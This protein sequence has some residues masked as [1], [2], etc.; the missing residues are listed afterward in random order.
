[1]PFQQSLEKRELINKEVKE[2]LELGINRPSNS[3][4]AAN[5]HLVDKKDTIAKRMVI[6]FRPLNAV[7]MTDSYPLPSSKMMLTCVSG[8][9]WFTMLDSCRG[10]NQIALH[11]STRQH[12]SRMMVFLNALSCQWESKM[13]RPHTR[14]SLTACSED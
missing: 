9:E 5:A 2:G 4:Y 7:T 14:E 8:S 12:L 1:M 10:F 11:P 13:V 6:D 3:P